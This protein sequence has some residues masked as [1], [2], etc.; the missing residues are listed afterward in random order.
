VQV[1][2]G[3]RDHR[4]LLFATYIHIDIGF[5]RLDSVALRKKYQRLN[6]HTIAHKL[7]GT[8]KLCY[9]IYLVATILMNC[10]P[11]TGCAKRRKKLHQI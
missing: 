11:R 6:G 1:I 7:N 8:T 2:L 4:Q 9:I 5:A 10:F 3:A